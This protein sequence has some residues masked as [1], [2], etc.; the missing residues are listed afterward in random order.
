MDLIQLAAGQVAEP[1]ASA[2]Q[3]VHAISISDL[4]QLRLWVEMCPEVPDG[5]WYKDFGSFNICGTGSY[6]KRS[7]SEGKLQRVK[8]CD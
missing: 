6:P 7:W 5:D 2:S 4:N 3:I 8:P 1:R